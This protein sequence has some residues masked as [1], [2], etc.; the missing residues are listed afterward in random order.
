MSDAHFHDLVDTALL[1]A[2][3][4]PPGWFDLS[5]FFRSTNS[6]F[7]VNTI[8]DVRRRLAQ[9]GFGQTHT[10]SEP[11]Y[12]RFFKINHEGRSRASEIRISQQAAVANRENVKIQNNITF[13]PV[14]NNTVT[15]SDSGSSP[16]GAAWFGAW[17][18]WA[19]VLVTVA[20]IFVTLKLTGKI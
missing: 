18:T 7:P 11:P 10:D 4:A 17:G 8:N 5:A 6:D 2:D 3:E 14:I 20:G 12:G 13:N 9:L 19:A 16:Q 15:S 1:A